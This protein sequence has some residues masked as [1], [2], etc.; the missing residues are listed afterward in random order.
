MRE[1]LVKSDLVECVIG[2]GKIYFSI[3]RWRHVL[4]YAEREKHILVKDM[5]CLLMQKRSNSKKCRE[6]FRR[7]SHTEDS[8]NLQRI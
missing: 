1:K 4:L 6:L 7:R 8:T 5:F 3:L 2:I